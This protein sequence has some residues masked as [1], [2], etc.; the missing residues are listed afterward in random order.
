MLDYQF[1]D[2]EMC[3]AVAQPAVSGVCRIIRCEALALFYNRNTFIVKDNTTVAPI[4]A[5]W[6]CA[7]AERHGQCL[8]D[9]LIISDYTDVASYYGRLLRGC[10]FVIHA[11]Q[12]EVREDGYP[13]TYKVSFVG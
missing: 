3:D 12:S 10:G 11:L 5:K 1:N 6:L 8:E 7:I 4:L 9:L 2:L 13:Y